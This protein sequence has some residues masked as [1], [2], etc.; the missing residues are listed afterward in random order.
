MYRS[1]VDVY[2][3]VMGSQQ[4][5]ELVL[6]SVLNCLYDSL[7]QMF[8]KNV[9][10]RTLM[11]NLDAVFLAVSCRYCR[12]RN[13]GRCCVEWWQISAGEMSDEMVDWKTSIVAH[14]LTDRSHPHFIVR[15]RVRGSSFASAL[16]RSHPHFVRTRV[17]GSS[18]APASA[19]VVHCWGPLLRVPILVTRL[20]VLS[21]LS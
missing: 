15:L 19:S 1:N 8:R 2:F 16:Y 14:A 11:D 20:L 3:Y 6:V 21:P 13:G 7:S 5:N 12:C 9:E 4:E 17:R 10:K 18:F